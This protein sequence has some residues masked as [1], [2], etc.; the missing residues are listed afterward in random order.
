MA[1][2][3]STL[4]ASVWNDCNE[5]FGRGYENTAYIFDRTFIDR[6]TSVYNSAEM[7]ITKL[8]LQTGKKGY[9]LHMP[10]N[11]PFNGTRIEDQDAAI[12][13]SMNK[14]VS[15]VLMADSPANA[16]AIRAMK[17]SN[18]VLVLERKVKGTDEALQAF[19][20]IGWENGATGRGATLDAYEDTAR[21]GWTITM[22]EEDASMPQ[23][24]LDYG[25]Y[26]ETKAALEALVADNPA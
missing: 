8:A 19:T 9:K 11:E 13:I 10:S 6:A 16:K 24:F 3:F 23:I 7:K 26:T 15:L 1:D 14:S 17:E 4:A 20:V 2:C 5:S 21:G 18:Y 12:G 25:G 22:T